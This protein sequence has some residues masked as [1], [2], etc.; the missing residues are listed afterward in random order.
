[1]EIERSII[2]TAPASRV[3]DIVADRFHEVGTWASMIDTSKELALNTGG[4]GVADRLCNTPQGIF[5][6]KVVNFDEERQTFS[7]VAY[8][9]LPGF[10]KEGGNTWW[11]E[12]VDDG[13]TQV[14]FRMKFDLNPIADVLMGWMLKRQ[15]GRLADDVADDLKVYAETGLVSER[16]RVAQSKYAKKAA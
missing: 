15:M 10:V 14:R 8:E 11:V 12:A 6:E 2:I 3:W 16:K 1:M 13:H 9:G 4:A 5:Q 7:Y